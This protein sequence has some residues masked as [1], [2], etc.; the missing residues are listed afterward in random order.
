MYPIRYHSPKS[1]AAVM[2]VTGRG[3][4]FESQNKNRIRVF[5]YPANKSVLEVEQQKKTPRQLMLAG[6]G[7]KVSERP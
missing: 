7:I 2:R 6:R 1:K 3:R 4:R 5:T